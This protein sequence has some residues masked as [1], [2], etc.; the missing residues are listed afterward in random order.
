MKKILMGL[1]TFCAMFVGCEN[2]KE[3]VPEVVSTNGSNAFTVDGKEYF[4]KVETQY[5]GDE[6][7]GAYSIV[8]QQDDPLV[9]L[10]ITFANEE[11]AG[12]EKHLTLTQNF[13][14]L[15]NGEVY[16]S[17]SGTAMG[18]LE[19]VSTEAKGDVSVKD[20]TVTIKNLKLTNR[21]RAIK[22]VSAILSF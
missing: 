12:S 2:K 5:F 9:L 10:Q 3:Y 20:R 1:L 19:F 17:L 11:D 8:C 18:A 13:M 21:E 14:R 7:T 22:T 6:K 16:I 4:G 15:E